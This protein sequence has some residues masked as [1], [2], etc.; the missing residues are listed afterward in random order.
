MT[1]VIKKFIIRSWL[2]KLWWQC[3]RT[4]SHL[5]QE[6][7][8]HNQ[9][10]NNH[11]QENVGSH[12]KKI[13]RAW[14]QRRSC[15]KTV[16]GVQSHLKSNL[17]PTSDAWRVQTKP[18]GART[19]GKEPWPPAETAPD[20]PV[21]VAVCGLRGS[22][23]SCP[24]G[25]GMGPKSS[26]RRSPLAPPY[27]CQAG[28]PQTGEQFYQRSSCTSAKVLGPVTTDFPTWDLAKGLRKGLEKVSFHSKTKEGQCQRVLK[29]P[30]GCTHF[31]HYQSHA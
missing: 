16:E 24:G 10:L 31:T 18:R 6:H 21:G 30:H 27:C 4:H 22:G 9:L 3:R 19:Q 28:D 13:S 26:W 17:R 1:T 5:L 15:N 2:S 11:R 14:G 29:L 23:S 20:L 7:Q 12:Q 8:N 25:P